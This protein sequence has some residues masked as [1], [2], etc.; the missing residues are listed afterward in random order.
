VRAFSVAVNPASQDIVLACGNG[1]LRRRHGAT[2]WRVESD[3]RV[4]E[5]LDVVPG[6]VGENTLL[7]TA[8]GMWIWDGAARWAML[9]TG[10]ACTFVSR[11][12]ALANGSVLAATEVGIAVYSSERQKWAHTGPAVPIRDVG[13][14]A[15]DK[16][17]VA[18][19]ER[20]GVYVSTDSGITWNRPGATAA[21]NVGLQSDSIYAVAVDS[22]VNSAAAAHLAAGGLSGTVWLSDDHGTTWHPIASPGGGDA[23]H[24]LAFHP[25]NGL[26][27]CGCGK[28]GLHVVEPTTGKTIDRALDRSFVSRILFVPEIELES[29]ES[30]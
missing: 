7:A 22:V 10:L 29:G 3:W 17:W 27:Y 12:R 1:L 11:I 25:D 24:S 4:T 15:D 9:N 21:N 8:H 2:S 28:S 30:A 16:G 6:W 14:W 5:V 23:I 13:S 20:T 18:G 26:L 19:S